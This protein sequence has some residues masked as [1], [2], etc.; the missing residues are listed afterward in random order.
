M[1]RHGAQCRGVDGRPGESCFCWD[2]MASFVL[3]QERLR[4]WRYRGRLFGGRPCGDSRVP[5]TGGRTG[6]SSG[7]GDVLSPHG[8]TAPGMVIQCP[9][10]RR[11]GEDGRT[12]PMAT[13]VTGPAV[14]TSRVVLGKRE[15]GVCSPFE[16]SAVLFRGCGVPAVREWAAQCHGA[17]TSLAAQRRTV[18]GMAIPGESV[19]Q[20]R[21]VIPRRV[22]SVARTCRCQ[23]IK[24]LSRGSGC[25]G[26]GP[27]GASSEVN[28]ARGVFS[29]RARRTS[30]EGA[31]SPRARRTSPEGAVRPIV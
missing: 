29:P 7:R 23:S 19:E 6:H 13:E 15:K 17:D 18:A 10:W 26:D 27:V 24:W 28:F 31:L 22:R 2:V 4:G 9:G 16:G 3:V 20:R 11:D 14:L 12:G 25:R 8:S 30:P 5:L 1:W 21:G